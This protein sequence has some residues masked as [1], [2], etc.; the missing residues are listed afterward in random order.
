MVEIL[1]KKDNFKLIPDVARRKKGCNMKSIWIFWGNLKTSRVAIF[2]FVRIFYTSAS[3]PHQLSIKK[4]F[5]YSS[6]RILINWA[7]S[8]RIR[9]PHQV[10]DYKVRLNRIIQLILDDSKWDRNPDSNRVLVQWTSAINQYCRGIA[11]RE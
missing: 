10:W 8:F 5:T 6:R 9:S 3:S 4:R 2:L 11:P 1:I 7:S